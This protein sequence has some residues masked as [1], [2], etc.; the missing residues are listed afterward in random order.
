ML[1]E[2]LPAVI[3]GKT[4]GSNDLEEARG[5]FSSV[6]TYID[7]CGGYSTVFTLQ[8]GT[9]LRA[10][11]IRDLFCTCVILHLKVYFMIRWS[12]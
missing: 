4:H 12:K 11:M 10:F 8:K 1:L 6:G 2:F 9:E 5:G 7:L 3:F